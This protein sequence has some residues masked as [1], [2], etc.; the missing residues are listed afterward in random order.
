M[1]PKVPPPVS[2]L[3]TI[4]LC[5]IPDWTSNN[6]VSTETMAWCHL[7]IPEVLVAVRQQWRKSSTNPHTNSPRCQTLLS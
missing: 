7:N 6:V 3:I 4:F 2:L 5:K 1:P